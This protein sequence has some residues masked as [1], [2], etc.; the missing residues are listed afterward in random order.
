VYDIP[1]LAFVNY[2]RLPNG[3]PSP[4]NTQAAFLTGATTYDPHGGISPFAVFSLDASYS[5]PTPQLPVLKKVT[6][7]L[8]IQ[9]LFDEKYFQYFYKQISPAAKCPV[10]VNNPTGSIYGCGPS[11][12]DG[13]PG[14][15]FTVFFTVT[16]RF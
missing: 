12:T 2:S 11:F 8:N 1:N 6:F 13:I 5:L 10:T 16:A 4:A 14:Q 7:D 3:Q 9:N 15:P